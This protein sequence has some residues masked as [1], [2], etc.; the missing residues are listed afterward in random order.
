MIHITDGLDRR[1]RIRSPLSFSHHFLQE[2][3]ACRE[4]HSALLLPAI[5][6]LAAGAHKEMCVGF[7]AACEWVHLS[8]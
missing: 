2:P 3:A 6:F 7:S 1:N 5:S 8:I 4:H